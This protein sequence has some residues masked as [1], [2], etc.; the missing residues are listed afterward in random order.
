MCLTAMLCLVLC[1][2]AL[3]GIL[4]LSPVLGEEEE[5]GNASGVVRGSS[6]HT[7][8]LWHANPQKN[9]HDCTNHQDQNLA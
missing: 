1:H 7:G 4:S 8:G 9:T 3:R 2:S 5:E 6:K